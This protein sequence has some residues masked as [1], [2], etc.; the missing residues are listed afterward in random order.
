MDDPRNPEWF[1]II[2][3]A[4]AADATN[5]LIVWPVLIQLTALFTSPTTDWESVAATALRDG[6][7][8]GAPRRLTAVLAVF[9]TMARKV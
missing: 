6:P 4:Q 3:V 9:I 2:G 8:C 5:S 7:D 1:T